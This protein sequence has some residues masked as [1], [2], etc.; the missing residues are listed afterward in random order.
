MEFWE[1]A[2]L[3]VGG[4]WLIGR[5]SR[6]SANHPI[7]SVANAVA[8]SK[9]QQNLTTM[10]NTSGSIAVV[11]GE[12]LT[13]GPEPMPVAVPK[14]NI[15]AAQRPVTAQPVISS[16]TANGFVPRP[17]SPGLLSRVSLNPRVVSV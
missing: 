3:V 2:L 16:L 11:A 8:V 6:N 1:G 10:T 4:I 7:N 15:L 5:V 14:F 17:V 13:G 12:P 9:T